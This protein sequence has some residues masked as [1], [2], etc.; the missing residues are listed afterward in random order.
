MELGINTKSTKTQYFPLAVVLSV[1]TIALYG[2]TITRWEHEQW[3]K[4]DPGHQGAVPTVVVGV[5]PPF[6][7]SAG[8]QPVVSDSRQPVTSETRQI[9]SAVEIDLRCHASSFPNAKGNA[10][11]R[12]MCPGRLRVVCDAGHDDPE[13]APVTTKDAVCTV[14]EPKTMWKPR[15]AVSFPATCPNCRCE[16]EN[17]LQP[18]DRDAAT[19]TL[20]HI[21]DLRGSFCELGI[22]SPPVSYLLTDVDEL[23]FVFVVSNG[24][25]GTTFLGQMSKWREHLGPGKK[26]PPGFGVSHEVEADKPYLVTVPWNRT[27]CEDGL[28][29]TA[30]R[31]VPRIVNLMRARKQHTWIEAGHQTLLGIIPALSQVLGKR[32]RFVRMRRNRI[33]VAYSFAQKGQGPCSPTCK[34][35]LCPLDPLVRCPVDG[36]IWRSMSVFQQFLWFVDELECQWQSFLSSSPDEVVVTELNWDK[37]ITGA[38]LLMVAKFAG[39]N[40]VFLRD[41]TNQTKR[42]NDHVHDASRSSKNYTALHE[43]DRGYQTLLGLTD[44]TIYTCIPPLQ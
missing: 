28:K 14:L 29:Y 25:T 9:V 38:D 3:D 42:A 23:T 36:L 16:A 33:D 1:A 19:Q 8:L 13:C 35:C 34:F 44:C 15:C 5:P 4:F 37:A 24:H 41:P 43:E 31:K 17:T 27:Y 39:M 6:L 26:L 11:E 12:C 2:A 22:D 40:D 10:L 18:A 21:T 30:E 7:P 20:G 32:A